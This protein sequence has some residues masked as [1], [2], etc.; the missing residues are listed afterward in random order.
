[1][2]DSWDEGPDS[3]DRLPDEESNPLS[4]PALKE[5]LDRWAEVY[6]TTPP[7]KR[8]Q[9][10]RELLQELQAAVSARGNTATAHTVSCPSCRQ[11][12]PAGQR[13]C[14]MCGSPLLAAPVEKDLPQAFAESSA[15]L[16]PGPLEQLRPEDDW[17]WLRD[18]TLARLN[19]PQPAE[20]RGLWKYVILGLVLLLAGFG[21]IEW[22][23]RTTPSMV[24]TAAPSPPASISQPQALNPPQSPAQP[25]QPEASEPASQPQVEPAIAT[26]DSDGEP[27]LP[28]KLSSPPP[29]AESTGAATDG[30]PE[31]LLAQHYL[32]DSP[33]SRNTT[34]A[35]KWLWKAVGKQNPSALV[36]LA[37]LYMRGDGVPKSC[38][39][40]RLLL[41]AA[42]KKGAPEAAEKLRRLD[43]NGCP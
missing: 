29:G 18:R 12:N 14:G 1:M 2:S 20:E 32:E 39:Q 5:H 9:A 16:I 24:R 42:V 23:S 30:E 40:A 4:N 10:M 3:P 34:E 31:L 7:E 21:Y 11:T 33:G 25:P 8:D 41:A 35:A 13:F 43:L 6:F 22:L 28:A 37:D 26:H 36:L 38:D 19:D 15:T 17:Q 27:P